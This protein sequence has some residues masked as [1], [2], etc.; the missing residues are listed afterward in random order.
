M[1]SFFH[2]SSLCVISCINMLSGF[3]ML[4]CLAAC[5][6]LPLFFIFP[7]WNFRREWYTWTLQIYIAASGEK[8]IQQHFIFLQIFSARCIYAFPSSSM[9]ITHLARSVSKYAPVC[10][11]IRS[12]PT[13]HEWILQTSHTTQ[14]PQRLGK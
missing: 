13:D 14:S 5:L 1:H 8:G 9:M 2:A 11:L 6:W 12:S 3:G 4:H 10:A 7:L